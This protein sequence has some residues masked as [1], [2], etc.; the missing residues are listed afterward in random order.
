MLMQYRPKPSELFWYIS[1]TLKICS[2]RY[3]NNKSPKNNNVHK[4]IASSLNCFQSK[5]QAQ[6][7]LAFI[8]ATL[9]SIHGVEGRG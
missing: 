2:A 7:A 4:E 9:K 1:R 8:T 5:E 6:Q 3:L